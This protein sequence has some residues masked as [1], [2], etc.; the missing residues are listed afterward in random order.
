MRSSTTRLAITGFAL[1][2][3]TT[4][5]PG[6]NCLTQFAPDEYGKE[7]VEVD[8]LELE[9]FCYAVAI[10]EPSAVPLDRVDVSLLVLKYTNDGML[11]AWDGPFGV[12]VT[13]DGYDD[14]LFLPVLFDT[15]ER[16]HYFVAPAHPAGIDGGTAR[17]SFHDTEIAC[18]DELELTLEPLPPGP[19]GTFEEIIAASTELTRALVE[20]W[21]FDPD[22]IVHT[23]HDE[24]PAMM[25]PLALRLWVMDH[26]DNPDS[27]MA[28]LEDG[29]IMEITAEEKA[30]ADALLARS[31]ILEGLQEALQAVV[32]EG[33]EYAI[34]PVFSLQQPLRD[35]DIATI[36]QPL[37]SFLSNRVD[38]EINDADELR[39]YMWKAHNAEAL[40]GTVEL[41][42][43]AFS[44]IGL[45]PGVGIAG[46]L[47]GLFFTF[48]L[49]LRSAHANTL[50]RVLVDPSV[51]DY[52]SLIWEDDESIHSFS[53][54][55]VTAESLGW[56]ATADIVDALADVVT[57]IL[58][59]LVQFRSEVPGAFG[60]LA[61]DRTV[62]LIE[63]AVE[64]L[65]MGNALAN[66]FVANILGLVTSAA[67]SGGVD[68]LYE[69]QGICY[70]KPG[71]WGPFTLGN[72]H[73]EVRY[74]SAVGNRGRAEDHER[75]FC[76]EGF[77]PGLSD[78]DYEQMFIGTG[79][80]LVN[81]I[82]FPPDTNELSSRW[83][84]PVRVD[85][86]DVHVHWSDRSAHPGDVIT[87]T[88]EVNL[89]HDT[90]AQWLVLSEGAQIL[91]TD[92]TPDGFHS[93]E[94]QTPTDPDQF[95]VFLVLQSRSTD[96]LRTPECDPPPRQALQIIRNDEYLDI[97]PK[98]KCIGEGGELQYE[99][100]IS[101]RTDNPT[102]TW[103]S[104]GGSIDDNGLFRGTEVGEFTVRARLD[105]T[106]LE[107]S[108]LV[109]VGGCECYFNVRLSG[110]VN[111]SFGRYGG[112]TANY[113]QNNIDISFR[114]LPDA[115]D[116]GN[117]GFFTPLAIQ[118]G[119]AGIL[120]AG[121]SLAYDGL[122]LSIYDEIDNF[123]V[124]MGRGTLT[125]HR[126]T[127]DDYIQGT[128][129]GEARRS[130]QLMEV[131]EAA[132]AGGGLDGWEEV[133]FGPRTTIRVDFMT[134]IYNPF[135]N[136]MGIAFHDC[137]G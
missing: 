126:W 38:V 23:P 43:T 14:E 125:I 29:E 36:E 15:E 4:S 135:R 39:S 22:E 8:E 85:P 44:L 12:E 107:E 33:H 51:D 19:E 102:I 133:A 113:V 114:T 10:E 50:P 115:L 35:D 32:D 92:S 9:P 61:G 48:D 97:D 103:S 67:Q 134:P 99:A 21:G 137:P 42:Q 95:P 45:V 63:A 129:E 76:N 70:V 132:A 37:C 105:G 131:F 3:V 31:G 82:G 72:R 120:P 118:E 112:L 77:V 65:N 7:Y 53:G 86:L 130:F 47:I 104:T 68:F 58:S 40:R 1:F 108:A 110:E 119:G 60:E 18:D 122:S 5:L 13:Y 88:G 25:V 121:G 17:L 116:R 6:C 127:D 123:M 54:Y 64:K 91:S 11:G 94:V 26:P 66:E 27:V 101:A 136:P 89:A 84:G 100:I 41:G 30:I 71:P 55:Q 69:G 128:F 96:G 28:I 34:D 80:I 83:H 59:Q 2:A 56:D 57:A 93:A 75:G 98:V 81:A 46:S 73:R 124:D 117:G 20:L 109:R 111:A 79:R 52:S 49:L 74:Q 106:D 24:L 16:V 87:V 78:N 62:G 90:R